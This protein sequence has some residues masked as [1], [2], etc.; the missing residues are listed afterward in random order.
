MVAEFLRGF[1]ILIIYFVTTIALAALLRHFVA[2]HS[3]LFRKTLHFILLCSLLILIYA[4]DT[5]WLAALC[6][7]SFIIFVFPILSLVARIKG[8]S[9]FLVE[10]KQYELRGSLIL[11][12]SMFAVMIMLCWGWLGDRA[13]AAACIY[14]WGVGDAAAALV[15][16]RWGRHPLE[17]RM[18]EGRK[19]MEGTLAMFISSFISVII[20]LIVR[21]GLPWHGYLL[22]SLLTA[23]VSAI[24]ELYSKNGH[25]TITC[26]FAAAFTLLP[27]LYLW[28]SISL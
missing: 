12:F 7:L 15:G 20:I 6:S 28:G 19:S 14:A 4:F 17:G 18:I 26:P 25:D 9:D 22:I 13:L 11:A 24:V 21:G 23:A 16:K 5:W 27:L 8:S 1:S 2:M 3:E 10:R